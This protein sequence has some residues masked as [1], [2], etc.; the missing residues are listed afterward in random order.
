MEEA[1]GINIPLLRKVVEWVEEQEALSTGKRQ[2]KQMIWFERNNWC[3][4]R[5]CVAGKVALLEGWEPVWEENETARVE[6]DGEV[7]GV[8]LVA[9]DLL[10]LNSFQADRLF[11]ARN[12]AADVRYYAEQLAGERL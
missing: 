11:A 3:G 10:G 5:C 12:T 2:W 1:N 4:T 7:Q 6:K 9:R 8:A